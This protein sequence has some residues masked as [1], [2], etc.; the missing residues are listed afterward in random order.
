MKESNQTSG[1][2]TAAELTRLAGWISEQLADETAGRQWIAES[3]AARIRYIT[4]QM[5]GAEA[6]GRLADSELEHDET[7][8][9]W[10]LNSLP[11]PA[12]PGDG[13][14]AVAEVLAG[15]PGDVALIVTQW[16]RAARTPPVAAGRLGA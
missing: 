4:L 8:R 6:L 10:L 7:E 11:V 13:D 2:D 3:A 5:L 1:P 15:M 16:L 12:Q 9:R 14:H